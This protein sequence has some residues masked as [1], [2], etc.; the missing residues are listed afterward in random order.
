M[1]KENSQQNKIFSG[2]EYPWF[3]IDFIHYQSNWHFFHMR[4]LFVHERDSCKINKHWWNKIQVFC[5]TRVYCNYHQHKPI[6]VHILLCSGI[7]LCDLLATAIRI[8]R[9][10][11]KRK[12][13]V[14]PPP[15]FIMPVVGRNQ[16]SGA[17]AAFLCALPRPSKNLKEKQRFTGGTLGGRTHV[18]CQPVLS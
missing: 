8:A 2:W 6:L 14:V 7:V 5:T 15:G 4:S 13:G 12:C 17:L 3:E 1:W 9:K 11:R 16:M 18:S 10:W